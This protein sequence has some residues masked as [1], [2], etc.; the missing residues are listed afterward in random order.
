MSQLAEAFGNYG[1]AQ[2][3]TVLVAAPNSTHAILVHKVVFS[4]SGVCEFHLLNGTGNQVRMEI[5]VR[6]DTAEVFDSPLTPGS[7]LPD[8]LFKVL[9]GEPLDVTTT[10][11]GDHSAHVWY[12]IVR[13]V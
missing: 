8:G 4:S 1:A 12:E 13:S 6:A 5:H 3:A 2:T 10:L 9:A 11:A 7:N